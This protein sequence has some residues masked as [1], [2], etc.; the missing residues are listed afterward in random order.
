M[1][2]GKS[3]WHRRVCTADI[4][5]RLGDLHRVCPPRPPRGC[6]GLSAVCS[7]PSDDNERSPEPPGL[8]SLVYTHP[9]SHPKP[10]R[11]RTRPNHTKFRR[12]GGFLFFWFSLVFSGFLLVF[13]WFSFVFFWFFFVFSGLWVFFCFLQRGAL[14]RSGGLL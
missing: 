9:E 6:C 11:T 4:E 2:N 7:L 8:I 10:T 1:G 5:R 3:Y 12:G 14:R 13:F